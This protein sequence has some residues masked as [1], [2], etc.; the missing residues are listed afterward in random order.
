MTTSDYKESERKYH[1]G[2]YVP[3]VTNVFWSTICGK[4]LS[5]H[6]RKD[7]M[8]KVGGVIRKVKLDV[9]IDI[10][11]FCGAILCNGYPVDVLITPS[12]IKVDLY[13]TWCDMYTDK[14]RYSVILKNDVQKHLCSTS[15]TVFNKGV[16]TRLK[17]VRRPSLCINVMDKDLILKTL[18]DHRRNR[19]KSLWVHK[20]K[21]TKFATAQFNF[22]HGWHCTRCDSAF[23]TLTDFLK[24]AELNLVESSFKMMLSTGEIKTDLAPPKL[25]PPDLRYHFPLDTRTLVLRL[26]SL[27]SR[28]R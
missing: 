5:T 2:Q 1:L 27:Q 9:E 16:F 15:C 14:V 7:E 24:H 21:S 12:S 20:L 11:G 18:K 13:E 3:P 17:I 28:G 4:A 8:K 22:V 23:N 10:T 26:R 6:T 19:I 25:H